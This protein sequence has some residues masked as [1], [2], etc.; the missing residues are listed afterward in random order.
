MNYSAANITTVVMFCM[1]LYLIVGR[2]RTSATA[3]WPL[4][5]YAF[6]VGYHQALPSRLEPSVVY[7]AVVSALFLRFEFLH[8]HLLKII[9]ACELICLTYFAW[10]FVELVG[11]T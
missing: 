3:S 11:L 1:T 2:F 10:R 4:F 8:R 5:Y 9:R 6:L 7:G